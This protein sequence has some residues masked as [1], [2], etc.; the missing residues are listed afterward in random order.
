[1]N[2][3][4]APEHFFTATVPGDRERAYVD[5]QQLLVAEFDRQR[6]TDDRSVAPGVSV[7]DRFDYRML[8]HRERQ[9]VPYEFHQQHDGGAGRPG[10]QPGRPGHR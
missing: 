8:G 10:G 5:D 4:V 6:G 1:M 7:A 9:L 2:R 3:R